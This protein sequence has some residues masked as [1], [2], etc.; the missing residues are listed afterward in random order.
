MRSDGE[1]RDG[2]GG[3]PLDLAVM[4]RCQGQPEPRPGALANPVELVTG[5]K[6][7]D[8]HGQ[9]G[10]LRSRV[11]DEGDVWHFRDDCGEITALCGQ[12]AKFLIGAHV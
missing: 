1:G 4:G 2:E 5:A 9:P 12:I 11:E 10:Q 7:L 6:H 3:Q 8:R